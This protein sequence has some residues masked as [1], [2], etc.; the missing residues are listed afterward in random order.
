M[1]IVSKYITEIISTLQ[2]GS[3]RE[4]AYRPSFQRLIESLKP[5]LK[6]VNDPAHSEHGAPDFVFLKGD[7]IVGYTETKDIGVDLD[8]VEKGEQMQRYFG[9]SNLILTDYLEFRFYRNGEKYGDSISIGKSSGGIIVPNEKNYEL[10]ERAIKDFLESKPEKIKSGVRLAKIMGGKARRIRE[11]VAHYIS[12]KSEKSKELMDVYEVMK[13]LLVHDLDPDQF[14]NMYAQTLVYGLFV[15]RYH[16]DTQDTFSRAEA[17]DLVPKSNPLLQ[18]FFDHIAGTSFDKRLAYIVNELCEIFA[19]ANVHEIMEQYYS[20]PTLWGETKESP[21]PVIHFYEDFLKEY[22]SEQR[23]KYGAFYTPLPIVR[24]IVRAVDYIL[25]NEF[26]LSGGLADTHKIEITKTVQGQKKKENIHEV[27]ILDPATGTGTFLNEVIR[28]IHK[29]F[30][31][32]GGRWA[33]YVDDDLLPRIHGF[34]LMMAPYTIAHLKLGMT[35][36]DMGYEKFSKRLGVYLTNS[37]EEGYK[38]ENSL[39]GFGFMQSIAEES[40]EASKIKNEKPIMVVLGN[41]PYSGVSSNETDYANSL[42]EKYKIEPGGKQKLQERKHW[43][44]D[45]YVKFIAFAEDMIAKNGYGIV[46]FITNHGYLDNPTFRGMRWHM[47]QTFDSIYVLDLHGNSKKNEISPDGSKDE[48]VFNIQQGVAIMLAIKNKEKKMKGALAKIYRSDIWGKRADKFRQLNILSQENINWRLLDSQM[49]NFVFANEGSRELRK[50]YENGFSVDNFFL[51]N[52][53]GVVTM[54]DGFIVAESKEVLEDRIRTLL[55]ED[56]SEDMLKKEYNLGKNY[57]KWVIGNK[58]HISYDENNVVL[59]AYRPFDNKFTYFNNR[60]IWRHREDVMNNYLNKENVGLLFSRMTKGKSFAHVFISKNISEAIF[61]SPLTG[62]NAFNAPIYLYH[63]DGTKTVNF[64]AE[65]LE[66][67][68]SNL[69]GEAKPE[70]ILDYIYAV[71]YS[72][73]YREKYKEFLKIDFPRVPYPKDNEIFWK[74]VE[75]GKELRLLHLMESPKLREFITNFS[76][77][78][79]NIVEKLKYE[80][81]KVFINE[82]QYF[83]NVP[84]IAWNF[85]IGGYQPAQKWLKDRKGHALSNQDLEHYQKMIVALVETDK[86]MKD[87]DKIYE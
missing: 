17:R 4:H 72:P 68:K 71:L 73:S 19:V 47:M 22:D 8:K 87:I 20:H 45:D 14:A 2:T 41:P 56:I 30:E 55:I 63:K 75:M 84:E 34:E 67:I 31:G 42:V 74:L 7:L 10:L 39:F 36:R 52:S 33:S 12:E 3:A 46:G 50:E 54:G 40:Q 76:E 26:N 51:K 79:S 69:Q 6:I 38:L 13:K 1:E 64:N 48:N 24:F 27:Q 66:K 78:G 29:S 16:D 61:L 65:I 80:S 62:T 11:N 59:L 53:T 70:D 32:Q 9:Y 18:H 60:L 81:G 21:D 85:Y 23:V 5:E 86:I 77:S 35:L 37:L 83:S 43:L 15:A 44:N 57:A 25:K 28:H 82:T 58:K 49:P